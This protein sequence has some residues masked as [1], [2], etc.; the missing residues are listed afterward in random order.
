[1]LEPNWMFFREQYCSIALS[2]LVSSYPNA[3]DDKHFSSNAGDAMRGRGKTKYHKNKSEKSLCRISHD[4]CT[5][6]TISV[7]SVKTGQ[8]DG[9]A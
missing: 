4:I 5:K 1:M 2:F 8:S 7:P 6:G 3:L 9:R